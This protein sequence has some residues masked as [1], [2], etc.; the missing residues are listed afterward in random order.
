MTTIDFAAYERLT[1]IIRIGKKA[2]YVVTAL[3][4]DDE[5]AYPWGSARSMELSPSGGWRAH[6]EVSGLAEGSQDR[7]WG[8]EVIS[9]ETGERKA[10]PFA[11]GVRDDLRNGDHIMVDGGFAM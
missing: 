8:V 7:C 3:R 1:A 4:W 9:G 2:N 10:I 6:F 11:R 5:V